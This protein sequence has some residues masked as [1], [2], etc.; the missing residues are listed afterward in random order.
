M[1]DNLILKLS[2]ILFAVC[3]IV[4][5]VL[6]LVN[7]V[8][9][10]IIAEQ[11]A[12]KTAEAYAAVLSAPGFTPVEHDA[13][14]YPTIDKIEV[15]TDDSGWV[16]TTTF[17]GAQG[18]ITMIVGVASDYTCSGISITVHSETSGLGAIA[19]EN[20]EKGNSFRSQFVGK[21]DSVTVDQIDKIAGATIT[22]KA[23]TNAIVTAIQAVEA[24]G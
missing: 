11:L 20:S 17:S 22:S 12:A 6:A 9:E 10:P 18:S 5:L 4:A 24:L 15:A 7:S 8:T 21:D 13:E 3:A 23:V 14:A 2:G 16:V 1:K 19:A